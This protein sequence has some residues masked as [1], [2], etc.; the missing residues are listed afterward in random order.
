MFKIFNVFKSVIC[1]SIFLLFFVQLANAQ[2]VSKNCKSSLSNFA[3]NFIQKIENNKLKIGLA[4]GSIFQFNFQINELDIV[5]GKLLDSDKR[6]IYE[7]MEITECNYPNDNLH[8]LV[9]FKDTYSRTGTF[10]FP[11]YIVIPI[12]DKLFDKSQR[13][14]TVVDFR[15]GEFKTAIIALNN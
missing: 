10:K 6:I 11:A 14:K 2:F 3:N 13:V 5:T 15:W 8:Y 9:A 4:D 12:T 1:L 7:G